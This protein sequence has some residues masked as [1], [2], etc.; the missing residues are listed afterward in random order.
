MPRSISEVNALRNSIRAAEAQESSSHGHHGYDP[1]QPR[2]SAGHSDGGQWTN[3]P[4]TPSSPRRD[5]TV[6]HTGKESWGSFAN[7]YRP[8][9]SLAEQRVFNRDGSRIVSEFNEPG[10]GEDWDERHTVITKDGRK[11]TL[12]IAGDVQRT[13]NE[14]GQ[15]IAASRWTEEGPDDLPRVQQAFL[16]LIPTIPPTVTTTIELGLILF[17]WLAGRKQQ[18]RVAI[19]GFKARRYRGQG[20]PEEPDAAFVSEL[21][22]EEVKEVCKKLDDAQERTDDAVDKVRKAGGY[23][24]ASDFGTKVH[25]IIADGINNLGNRNYI[26]EVSVMKSKLEAAYYSKLDTVRVDV[27]ENRPRSRTVC[28]YDPKTGSKGLSLPRMAELA[29]TAE[30]EFPGTKWIIV[31]EVRPGQK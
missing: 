14:S 30:R 9:G 25:K 22:R 5:V 7:L 3:K 31:I 15:L 24:N 2:V 21:T 27:F 4:G 6:D 29:N 11:L 12:E 17:A 28:I 8:D 20:S 26:A 10:S 13:Y 19:F 1:N 18:D 16:P 23:S